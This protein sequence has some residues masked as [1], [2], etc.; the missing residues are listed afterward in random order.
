MALM[1]FAVKQ[2]GSSEWVEFNAPRDIIQVISEAAW[3]YQIIL[4]G[5]R[6]ERV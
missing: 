2:S 4:L 3:W 6:G 1:L 5:D